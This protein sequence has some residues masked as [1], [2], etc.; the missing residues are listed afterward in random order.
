MVLIGEETYFEIRQVSH[1]GNADTPLAYK[2]FS[3]FIISFLVSP[4]MLFRK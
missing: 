4:F 3:S 1:V 2:A